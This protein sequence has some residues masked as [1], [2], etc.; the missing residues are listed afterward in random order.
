MKKTTTS[1]RI[2]IITGG[3]SGIGLAIATKFVSAGI[4]TLI[5]GRDKKKLDEATARLGDSCHAIVQD[6]NDLGSIPGLVRR[7]ADQY[8]RKSGAATAPRDP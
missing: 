8:G 3:G 6:L 5:I 1:Q 7:I 2:A 4:L